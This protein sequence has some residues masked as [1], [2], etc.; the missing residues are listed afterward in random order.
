M[1]VLGCRQDVK[2]FVSAGPVAVT[3]H[4]QLLEHVERPIHGRGDRVRVDLSAPLHEL[5]AGHVT[6]GPGEDLDQG[7]ALGRPA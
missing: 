4:A 5:G 1:S 3:Q 6:V 7:P 2:L